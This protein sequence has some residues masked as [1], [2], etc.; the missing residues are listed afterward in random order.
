MRVAFVGAGEVTVKTAEILIQRGHKVVVVERD[1]ARIEELTDSLDC[2]FLEGDG[3]NPAVLKEVDPKGTDAL[4]CLTDKDQDNIIAGLVGQSLGFHRVI[5]RI[6]NP[7]YENICI[8][9]GLT[10][11]IIPPR[12]IG[13]F[14]ADMVEG[15]DILELSTVIRGEAR[16][17]VFTATEKDAGAVS[18][19]DLPGNAQVICFYRD[20][21]FS[22]ADRDTRLTAG[23]DVVILT[24]SKNLPTLE[25]RWKPP[26]PRANHTD[27]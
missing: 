2:S 7:E 14:L 1:K 25:E 6:V 9:L 11:T 16:F 3:S 22:L 8:E 17:F 24:H 23:D 5:T 27:R 10:D 18:E 20:G 13:R 4:I 15:Q 12:T 26:M 19:L 21:E